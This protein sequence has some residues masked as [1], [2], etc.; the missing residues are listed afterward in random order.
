MLTTT[1]DGFHYALT[2]VSSRGKLLSIS[3]EIQA[4]LEKSLNKSSPCG[5]I[6]A[7]VT[8]YLVYRDT[9]PLMSNILVPQWASRPSRLGSTH[10]CNQ[11]QRGTWP[12]DDWNSSPMWEL[13]AHLEPIQFNAWLKQ[14]VV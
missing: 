4:K 11:G 8:Q 10:T 6:N 3:Q 13:S 2:L 1:I 9:T 14:P 5:G 7:N 12:P